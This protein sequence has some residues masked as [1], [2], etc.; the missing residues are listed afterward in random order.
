MLKDLG[1]AA[2]GADPGEAEEDRGQNRERGV[3]AKLVQMTPKH[4]QAEKRVQKKVHHCI[5][6]SY[7]PA[8]P[9]PRR[10]APQSVQ[11]SLK[12]PGASSV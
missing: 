2:S 1:Y 11:K 12:R 6:P 4:Q 10:R 3:E 5:L 9:T 8:T 7:L